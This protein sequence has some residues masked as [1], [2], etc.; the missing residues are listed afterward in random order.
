MIETLE[1]LGLQPSRVRA[2]R[3]A[4]AGIGRGYLRGVESQED[5]ADRQIGLVAAGTNL[6]RAAAHSLL[7][8][9]T[10]QGLSLFRDAARA[11]TVAGAAYGAFVET[12]AQQRHPG[13]QFELPTPKHPA[14]VWRLWSPDVAFGSAGRWSDEIFQK[15]ARF[16]RDMDVYRTER[17]GLLGLPVATYLELFDAA[18]A[19]VRDTGEHALREALLPILA[20]YAAAVKRCREDRYHWLR[21]ALPIHPVEPDVLGILLAL[22]A[23]LRTR[24]ASITRLITDMPVGSDALTLLRGSLKQYGVW[25]AQ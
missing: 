3:D 13:N 21:L 9:D 17:V 11:Y 25:H 23:W 19:S 2:M 16:R 10:D 4:C 1:R 6:R 14:D 7:L 22:D 15:I 20:A 8:G 5:A 12:L 18:I 24:Q